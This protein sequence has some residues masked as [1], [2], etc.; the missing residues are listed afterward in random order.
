MIRAFTI[1]AVTCFALPALAAEKQT[2]ATSPSDHASY[3]SVHARELQNQY[4]AKQAHNIL[5][6]RGFVNISALDRDEDGRWAG[7]AI[8]DGKTIFV[9]V[10]LPKP[11]VADVTN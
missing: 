4:D 6:S 1:A 2:A 7:T 11:P 10:E 5:A 9:A 8:K 3:A